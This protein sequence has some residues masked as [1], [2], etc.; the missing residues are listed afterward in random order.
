[1]SALETLSRRLCRRSL[2]LNDL[3]FVA[4]ILEFRSR[5]SESAIS[6]DSLTMNAKDSAGEP[7]NSLENEAPET[8]EVR[9]H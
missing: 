5:S 2:L 6:V 9:S 8:K 3:T 4:N 1:M 7:D